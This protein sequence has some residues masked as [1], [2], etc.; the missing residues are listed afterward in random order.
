MNEREFSVLWVR[1]LWLAMARTGKGY[2]RDSGRN[3]GKGDDRRKD[4]VGTTKLTRRLALKV[5]VA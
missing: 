4:K 3:T 5:Q 1:Q 2:R